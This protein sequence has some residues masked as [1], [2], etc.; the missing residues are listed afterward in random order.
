MIHHKFHLNTS[1]FKYGL[2]TNKG[3]QNLSKIVT[4]K[5]GKNIS[6]LHKLALYINR[7]ECK[8]L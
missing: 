6:L 3:N 5:S 8:S 2:F 7:E 4:G 1:S